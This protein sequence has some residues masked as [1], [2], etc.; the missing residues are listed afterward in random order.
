MSGDEG[1]TQVPWPIWAVVT[2]MVAIITAYSVIKAG[3]PAEPP[4]PIAK[5]THPAP[6]EARAQPSKPPDVYTVEMSNCD[7]GGQAFV[8]GSL[9][10]RVG[11]GDASGPLNITRYLKPGEN[12]IKFEV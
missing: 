8:N 6:L 12:E 10:G 4:P 3:R 5:P 1:K 9:V 2:L 11:F 7:D